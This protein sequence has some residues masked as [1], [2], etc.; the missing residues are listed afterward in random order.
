MSKILPSDHQEYSKLIEE[1]HS[2][3]SAAKILG[4]SRVNV[5]TVKS[6]LYYEGKVFPTRD[7]GDV[8]V[9]DYINGHKVLVKF[10]ESGYETFTSTSHIKEG[11]IKDKLSPTVCGVG[12]LGDIKEK[13][14]GT[15]FFAY[16]AWVGMIERCYSDSKPSYQKTYAGCTVADNFKYFPYFKDW[17]NNQI[18][19]GNK[20]WQLDKDI[21]VKGNKVY[22]EDT[23]CFV[24]PAING[25]LIK[26]NKTRGCN[27]IGVSF[28]K[29]LKKFSSLVRIKGKQRVLGY[30]DSSEEAFYAYKAAKEAYIK[31][32]VNEWKEQIDPRVYEALMNYQVEITD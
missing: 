17:C 27:P 25:L 11:A 28:Q 5:K 23:C 26:S 8:V 22:G 7:F 30:Y 20:G 4:I 13:L 9:L 32:V 12:I 21:L 19:F 2:Q 1:G 18:G 3:R 10:V 24:P 29:S 6:K 31:E 16:R 14:E 15:D